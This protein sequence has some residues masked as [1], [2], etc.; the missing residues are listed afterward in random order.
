MFRLFPDWYF[1]YKIFTTY[2]FNFWRQVIVF[3]FPLGFSS[4]AMNIMCIDCY[5]GI[6]L[7]Y[8][9]R[10]ISHS[11]SVCWILLL[12]VFWTYLRH[13]YSYGYRLFVFFFTNKS[14]RSSFT[15]ILGLTL[16][17]CLGDLTDKSRELWEYVKT[18]TTFNF[19][20]KTS[21]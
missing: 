15:F 9:L 4:S 6:G 21:W 19:V 2:N 10:L 1:I 13:I 3:P 7:I 8:F 5:L 18:T 14:N 20:Y 11:F 12:P 17:W 16:S